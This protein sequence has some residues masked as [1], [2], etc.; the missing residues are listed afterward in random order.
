MGCFGYK[1]EGWCFRFGIQ[2]LGFWLQGLGFRAYGAGSRSI[3]GKTESLKNPNEKIPTS[4]NRMVRTLK[5]P[6]SLR[7][8]RAEPIKTILKNPYGSF[9]KQG[10]LIWHSK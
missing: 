4:R 7:E 2:G 6:Y 3:S 10:T 5:K 1:E 9:R 8:T